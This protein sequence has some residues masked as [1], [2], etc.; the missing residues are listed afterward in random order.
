VHDE[1]SGFRDR[2]RTLPHVSRVPC[3]EDPRQFLDLAF[4]YYI[5][6]RFAALNRL[7]IAP[8]L[9]HHAVELLIKYTVLK[10]VPEQHGT[11][12]TER[13]KERYGRRLNALWNQYKAQVVGSGLARFD[14]VINELHPLGGAQVPWLSR[15]RRRHDVV[16]IEPTGR[17]HPRNEQAREGLRLQPAGG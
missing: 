5:A 14:P 7:R 11:A 12:E 13:I 1:V 2:R 16:R 3:A 4:G 17:R 6:G 9:M 15:E 8:N 10:D